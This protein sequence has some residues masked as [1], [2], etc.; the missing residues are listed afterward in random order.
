MKIRPLDKEWTR[1]YDEEYKSDCARRDRLYP[2]SH[3][4]YVFVSVHQPSKRWIETDT[5]FD[6]IDCV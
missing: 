5:V 1:K 3:G 6:L 4:S 2:T